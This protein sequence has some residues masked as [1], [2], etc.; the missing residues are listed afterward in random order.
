M[1]GEPRFELCKLKL[2]TLKLGSL[3]RQQIELEVV[4]DRHFIEESSEFRLHQCEALGQ[5]LAGGQQVRGRRRRLGAVAL[6]ISIAA[7]GSATMPVQLFS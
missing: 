6:V 1:A 5:A 3:D 7:H 4:T 2:D